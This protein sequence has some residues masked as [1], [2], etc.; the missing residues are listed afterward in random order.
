MAAA[1][2]TSAGD[3]KPQPSKCGVYGLAG[4]HG[5]RTGLDDAQSSA[6]TRA[7]DDT[8]GFQNPHSRT[9]WVLVL[10]LEYQR[11]TNKIRLLIW[12]IFC[13][14]SLARPS[15]RFGPL[16][17]SNLKADTGLWFAST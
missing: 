16:S 2:T 4:C 10:F 12:S 5:N 6:A 14:L 17:R 8:L 11:Y 9:L 13:V 1:P 7:Q 15:W 3:M